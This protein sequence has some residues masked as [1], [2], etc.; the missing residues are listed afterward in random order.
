MYILTQHQQTVKKKKL[1]CLK[2]FASSLDHVLYC[3][4]VDVSNN[5]VN[6]FHHLQT[7]DCHVP[8][9]QNSE[10]QWPLEQQM[11]PPPK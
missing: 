5:R 3:R 4:L 10:G 8:T 2:Y 7:K 9:L 6:A 11:P 1:I